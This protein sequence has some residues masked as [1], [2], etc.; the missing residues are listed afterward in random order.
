VKRRVRFL[1]PLNDLGEYSKD[2]IVALVFRGKKYGNAKF[3]QAAKITFRCREAIRS[4]N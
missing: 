2:E 3:K 4:E 1:S